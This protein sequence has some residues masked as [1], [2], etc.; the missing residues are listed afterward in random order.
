ML[1]NNLYS[2]VMR[3]MFLLKSFTMRSLLVIFLF[4]F[5]STFSCAKSLNSAPA[6]CFFS[7]EWHIFVING[8]PDNAIGAHVYDSKGKPEC[9]HCMLAPDEVLDWYFCPRGTTYYGDFTWGKFN[10]TM[11][12]FS[13]HISNICFHYKFVLGTQHCYW[14]VRPHGFYVSRFNLSYT[15]SNWIYQGPWNWN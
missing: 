9:D 4:F 3:G 10:K 14:L 11:T 6:N 12:L 7:P 8:L 15:D 2:H 13:K 1:E 5:I